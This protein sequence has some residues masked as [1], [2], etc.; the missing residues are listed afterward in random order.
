MAEQ[1]PLSVDKFVGIT[2]VVLAFLFLGPCFSPARWN[3]V[4]I[5]PETVSEVGRE[6]LLETHPGA[7][8][9]D[10]KVYRTPKAGAIMYGYSARYTLDGDET[11]HTFYAEGDNQ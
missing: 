1:Q 8:I 7:I 6:T 3:G 4:S 2:L 5:D 9:L 11:I 10:D